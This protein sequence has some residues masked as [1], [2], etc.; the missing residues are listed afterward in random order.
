MLTADD[1]NENPLDSY[2]KMLKFYKSQNLDS[3]KILMDE[4]DSMIEISEDFLKNRNADWI[5]KIE[6]LIRESPVF[7]AVGA[8]HLAGKDGVLNLLKE[9]GYTI[10]P[11]K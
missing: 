11:V 2:N 10:T 7:I 1:L 5:P 6:K 8:G 4:D 3:L 9:N